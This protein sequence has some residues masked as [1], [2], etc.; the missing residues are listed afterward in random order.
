M[1]IIHVFFLLMKLSQD[2]KQDTYLLT[3]CP[4]KNPER[5]REQYQVGNFKGTTRTVFT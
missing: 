2:E 3:S 4:H 5:G 1:Y